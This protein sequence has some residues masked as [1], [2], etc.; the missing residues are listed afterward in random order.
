MRAIVKVGRDTRFPTF[1]T[2]LPVLRRA[3]KH[4]PANLR[5]ESARRLAIP[6]VRLLASLLAA[7]E[8]EAGPF[9]F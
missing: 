1:S 8:E 3:I 6:R 4:L 5:L 7:I 2:V 9:L